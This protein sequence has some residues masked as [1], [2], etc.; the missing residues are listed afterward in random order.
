LGV[1]TIIKRELR[2]YSCTKCVYSLWSNTKCRLRWA[3][4][5]LDWSI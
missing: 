3:H 5:R 2:K 4:N 1:N